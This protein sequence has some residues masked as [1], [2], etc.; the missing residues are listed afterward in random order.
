VNV[1]L[2]RHGATTWNASRRFQGRTDVPLSAEGRRQAQAIAAVLDGEPV[3]RIYSSDLARALETARILAESRGIEIVSDPRLREFDFGRWEGLTWEQIVATDSQFADRA[4][5]A[6]K[7]Y[8]PEG[9][10]S[11]A[12]VCA[13]IQSFFDDLQRERSDA[14]FAIVTHAG[15]L[16][17]TLNVLGLAN[18]GATA[19]RGGISFSPGGI[20]RVT[21]DGGRARLVALNDLR[22]LDPTG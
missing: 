8:A 6:A 5:T 20:T 17:A 1:T 9:G 14:S 2:I 13:R 15:P 18:D 4:P 10:E 22:H 21:I 3:E 12:A 19:D 11:F 7:R 16:H